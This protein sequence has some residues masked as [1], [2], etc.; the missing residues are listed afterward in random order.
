MS[1]LCACAHVVSCHQSALV[2][3]SLAK[4]SIEHSNDRDK[5]KWRDDEMLL[6]IYGVNS[7]QAKRI[8]VGC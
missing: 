7:V 8:M 3:H 5:G 1:H 4:I 2:P 6:D